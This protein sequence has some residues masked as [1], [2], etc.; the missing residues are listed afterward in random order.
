V[1]ARYPRQRRMHLID[2]RREVAGR[3][4]IVTDIGRDDFGGQSDEITA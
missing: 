1:A 4:A 2:Q 3:N